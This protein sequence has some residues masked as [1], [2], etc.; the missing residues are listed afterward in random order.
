MIYAARSHSTVSIF[1]VVG[2]KKEMGVSERVAKLIAV[3]DVM[4]QTLL[5]Q[6]MS[7]DEWDLDWVVVTERDIYLSSVAQ[8]LPL[9]VRASWRRQPESQRKW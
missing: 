4:V 6:Q 5:L 7:V 9:Y 1:V 3:C 2:E 8:S